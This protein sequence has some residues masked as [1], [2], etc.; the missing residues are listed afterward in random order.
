MDGLGSCKQLREA[1]AGQTAVGIKLEGCRKALYYGRLALTFV[2]QQQ[3]ATREIRECV[4]RMCSRRSFR[5]GKRVRFLFWERGLA[6]DQSGSCAKCRHGLAQ[7][8]VDR[9]F[10]GMAMAGS[11]AMP[12]AWSSRH[13]LGCR[14]S[15]HCWLARDSGGEGWPTGLALRKSPLLVFFPWTPILM[16]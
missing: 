13:Q 15:P 2:L 6:P 14:S 10:W 16:Q 11:S 1:G 5:A 4:Y 9:H 8:P 12:M 7:R 3:E